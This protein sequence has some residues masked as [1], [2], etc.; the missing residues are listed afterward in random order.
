MPVMAGLSG[1]GHKFTVTVTAVTVT[2][3]GRL[4]RQNVDSVN[5]QRI[6]S[7]FQVA[8]LAAF[9]MPGPLSLS[10]RLT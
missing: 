4:D 10:P 5:L 9:K 6:V 2:A 7:K 1:L 8:N 3:P